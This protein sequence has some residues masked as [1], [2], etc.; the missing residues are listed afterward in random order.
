M[1][2]VAVG[3]LAILVLVGGFFGCAFSK[4]NSMIAQDERV[5]MAQAN[6]DSNLQRRL[7]LIPNLVETVKGATKYEGETLV[8]ITEGR[9]QILGL[10]KEFGEAMKKGDRS[11]METLE[12]ALMSSV[13]AFT[14]LAAEAYPNLKATEAFKDLMTQL[15]GTEN[16]INASRMDYNAAVAA[17]NTNIRTWGWM[18]LCGGFET[19]EPFKASAEAGKAPAVNFK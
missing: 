12:T 5:T 3:F 4:R 9:N 19:R 7:E 8:K 10:A 18:P 1:K 11:K 17:L 14:G 16:R 13:R 15:E 2:I 6:I